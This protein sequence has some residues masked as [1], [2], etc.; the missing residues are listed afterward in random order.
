MK[1]LHPVGFVYE[2]LATTDAVFGSAWDLSKKGFKGVV[3]NEKADW[4]PYLFDLIYSHQAPLNFETSSC[5]SHG[6]CNAVEL[7][8]NLVHG[9][10]FDLSDRFLAKISGTSPAGGNT[11]KVVADALRHKWSPKESD[12]PTSVAKTQDEFYAEIP[13]TV[14][15]LA[16]ENR[17][18][19]NFGYERLNPD[20]AT[21]KEALK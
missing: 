9:K 3:L 20:V 10:L 15:Q 19:L 16:L 21:M 8:N 17:G 14:K 18:T 6:T 1:P 4:Q 7:L 2:S 11:P 12:W 13:E 5:V